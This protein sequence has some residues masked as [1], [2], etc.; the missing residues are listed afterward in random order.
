MEQIDNSVWEYVRGAA[1]MLTFLIYHWVGRKIGHS[2]WV[3][4]SNYEKS[5]SSVVFFFIWPLTSLRNILADNST[6]PSVINFLLSKQGSKYSFGMTLEEELANI[7]GFMWLPK[8]VINLTLIF[9]IT[10]FFFLTT[11]FVTDKY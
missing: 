2:A 9:L 5:K 7:Y 4:S 3:I 10:I 11:G 6:R 1:M 8:L